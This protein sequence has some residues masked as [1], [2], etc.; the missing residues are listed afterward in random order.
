MGE[1]GLGRGVQ[2]TQQ[3][4]N[5]LAARLG[6]QVS[7]TIA[8]GDGAALAAAAEPLRAVVLQL[9]RQVDTPT[10]QPRLAAWAH[11]SIYQVSCED[12]FYLCYYF[13]F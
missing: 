9:E 6:P 13:L 11:A 12:V 10:V 5:A 3:S 4:A 1:A 2:V 8:A 7:A